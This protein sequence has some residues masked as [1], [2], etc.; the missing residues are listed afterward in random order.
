MILKRGSTQRQNV[1]VHMHIETS[2]MIALLCCF[3]YD[4][5]QS[6]NKHNWKD[7]VVSDKDITDVAIFTVFFK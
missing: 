2:Q 1:N 5:K 4:E 3:R 7:R 6:T